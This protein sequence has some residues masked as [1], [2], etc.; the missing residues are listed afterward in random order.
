MQRIIVCRNQKTTM[1][2]S[3]TRVCYEMP[4]QDIKHPAKKIKFQHNGSGTKS[5]TSQMPWEE[6]KEC[7]NETFITIHHDPQ[8]QVMENPYDLQRRFHPFDDEVKSITTV[9]M[10]NSSY[11]KNGRV[12]SGNMLINKFMGINSDEGMDVDECS[13]CAVDGDAA[14]SGE[15][16]ELDDAVYGTI[17]T[18]ETMVTEKTTNSTDKSEHH[19]LNLKSFMKLAKEAYI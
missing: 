7:M 16:E 3:K 2:H 12:D 18:E 6:H 1:S 5:S 10:W 15:I 13:I 14:A 11:M 4:S 8:K 9:D 19:K 17:I